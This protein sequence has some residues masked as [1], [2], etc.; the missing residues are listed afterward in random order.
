M[1]APGR[2]AD[3]LLVESLAGM[4]VQVVIAGGTVLFEEGA[5]SVPLEPRKVPCWFDGS[6][7]LPR[8]ITAEELVPLCDR[9]ANPSAW[10]T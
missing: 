3:M 6:V 5:W 8:A 7:H 4:Q 10:P 9:T 2:R 1:L